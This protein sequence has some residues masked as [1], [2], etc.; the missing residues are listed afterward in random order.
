VKAKNMSDNDPIRVRRLEPADVTAA[1]H[2]LTST[3]LCEGD[4]LAKRL[5][6][7]CDRPES[8]SFV[9]DRSGELVGVVLAVY[10]GFHVFLSHLA[11]L[12]G[13]QRHGVARHLHDELMA[14]AKRLGATGVITDSLLTT[15]GFFFQLG[16]RT[17]G[18]IFLIH[19]L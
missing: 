19:E 11:V 12:P 13:L 16:Y 6:G 17:P 2:I 14:T 15:T 4:G 3:R 8:I 1:C 9:A 7:L 18:A 5:T 10:N